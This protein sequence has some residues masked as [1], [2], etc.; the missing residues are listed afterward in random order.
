MRP[1]GE[2]GAIDLGAEIA[3]EFFIFGVAAVLAVTEYARSAEKNAAK[4]EQLQAVLR[5]LASTLHGLE[6]RAD[7]ADAR[8]AAAERDAAALAAMVAGLPLDAKEMKKRQQALEQQRQQQVLELQQQQQ[9][10][11]QQRQQQT[12]E[13]RQQQ[14]VLELQRQQN[15]LQQ[16]QP[17]AAAETAG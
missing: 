6:Q 1:L 3:G 12:L 10:L 9:V 8:Q 16:Q 4:E 13:Q 5:S 7:A 2:A 14:Q 17:A 15:N 11:E